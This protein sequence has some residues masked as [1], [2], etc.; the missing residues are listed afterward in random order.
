MQ[1]KVFKSGN[2]MV[3]SLPREITEYLQIRAGS[4]VSISLD[5]VRG[6]IVI[7]PAELPT[8]AASI[9]PE[10]ARQVADFIEEYRPAL[11]ELAK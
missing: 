2:S 1:R 8:A 10:F 9:T 4:E 5:R 11:E 6:R 3:V 7:E